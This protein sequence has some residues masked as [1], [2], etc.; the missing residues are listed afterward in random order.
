MFICN[1]MDLNY[2][3]QHLCLRDGAPLVF[4]E[5]AD[6]SMIMFKG[7]YYLFPS[8]TLGF[9]VSNDMARWEYHRLPD[10]LPLYDYAPDVRV[11][12]DWMY[13]SASRKS[14][15]CCF[16][17]TRDPLTGPFEEFPAGFAF[18]D[19]NLLIDDDG[20]VYLYWGCSSVEPLNGVE[21]NP[22]TM[23]QSGKPTAL[24][25]ANDEDHGYERPGNNHVPPFTPEEIEQR[26]QGLLYF[27]KIDPSTLTK[28]DVRRLKQS[29]GNAPFIEGSWV[30]KYHG[31]YYLQ[32]AFAGTE[33]NIYGDGVY[34]ADSP[35]GPFTLASNNPYSYKPGGFIT[36]AG[37]GS[38]MEDCHGN[39]WHTS[40]MR[41][42]TQYMFERRLGLWPAGFDEDGELFCNQR[43][44]DWPMRV[45]SG[46][47]DPW[48]EPEWMLLSYQKPVTASSFEEG[49]EPH[50]ATDENIQTWWRAADAAPGQTLTMDLGK[51]CTVH[52]VQ[53]NFADDGIQAPVPAPEQLHGEATQLRYIPGV[54]QP[55]RWVLE[56]SVDGENWTV[57]DNCAADRPHALVVRENGISLRY[58][59]LTVLEM[60]Y[61]QP[62][63]V[64]GLR[65]FGKSGGPLPS[66]PCFTARR[67]SDLDMSVEMEADGAVGYN[68][69]WGHAPDKLYHSCLAFNNKQTIGALVKGQGYY[70]R[71]DA[72][73]EAG[74][75]HGPVTAL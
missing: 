62:V 73:N 75:T 61:G 53:V 14:G 13:F 1:P 12:G 71:V 72:F 59:R 44:G 26:Y 60:P 16:Y 63:A 48:R 29:V 3:Y 58:L 20:R 10:S 65:V 31:R 52:A 43:Y 40:S 38:T 4:R 28:A 49:H 64:S 23:R 6:P 21:L 45:P 24:F 54:P 33:Y 39:W 19:P 35:L 9:Y 7:R 56:R 42:S 25:T 57:I 36:G 5:A 66:E 51:V 69:L 27:R 17:R 34:V 68:I 30:T 15:D 46:K 37:H 22:D 11:L 55:L 32:Y 18:W 50:L 70:V 41:I 47:F 67:T 2:Q 8:M 74:I